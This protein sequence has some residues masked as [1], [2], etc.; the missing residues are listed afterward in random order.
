VNLA[1]EVKFAGG[2]GNQLFQYATARRL[3]LRNHVRYLLFNADNYR[4]ESLNRRF[5][6]EKLRVK[7]KTLRNTRVKNIFAP[8]ARLNRLATAAG[9]HKRIDEGPFVI[10]PLD[11]E[12]GFFSSLHG[13]W[14]SEEYFRD[15]RSSLLEEL[16]PRNV[17]AYPAWVR[18]AS[19]VGIHVRRTDYLDEPRYG[20]LGK[21]YYRKAIDLIAKKVD[22]PFFV[23]FSD[24][25]A[26]C[27]MEFG[28]DFH[29]MKDS[30]WSAPH[31]HLHLMSK[32]AHQIIANSSFSWWGAWLNDNQSKIVVRP[33]RPFREPSLL[34]ASHYPAGWL[35]VDNAA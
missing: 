22:N 14:Q 23:F 35:I 34:H 25:L 33:S 7:G 13:F 20:F 3:A 24:D 2:L 9:L 31:L 29:Y 17:P 4:N 8:N 26:W 19:T 5:E 15:I 32:C 27:E 28:N 16:V 10:R 1:L 18:N 12:L 21:E 11:R 30:D 6:L